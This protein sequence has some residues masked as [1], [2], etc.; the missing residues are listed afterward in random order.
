M[1]KKIRSKIN[2][3]GIMNTLILVLKASLNKI[4][5][6]T[7]DTHYI[8]ALNV[9]KHS[10]EDLGSDISNKI[11]I[12]VLKL[13][14][15]ENELFSSFFTDRRKQIYQQRLSNPKIEGYGL[16]VDNQLAYSTWISYDKMQL[17]ENVV[18]PM[19]QNAALI[20]DSYCHPFFRRKGFH[21]I[22]NSFCIQI[23]KKKGLKYI[24]V[25]VLSYN[26]PAIKALKK[27]NLLI[28]FRFLTFRIFN[29][30]HLSLNYKKFIKKLEK[31]N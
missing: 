8:L 17:S 14:D 27:C 2:L 29:H 16:F 30:N 3:Y 1:L 15:F 28:I 9:S 19:P 26:R 5:R 31:V 7:W 10:K 18:L 25:F 4:F 11:D 24:L 12:R 23:I 6:I 22:M 20:I 21:I 13:E